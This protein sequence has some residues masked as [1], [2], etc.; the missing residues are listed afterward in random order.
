MTTKKSFEYPHIWFYDNKTDPRNSRLLKTNLTK[1]IEER[2]LINWIN[3]NVNET[4]FDSRSVIDGDIQGFSWF[5][6][7]IK[8]DYS[9]MEQT[10]FLP[11]FFANNLSTCRINIFFLE[12]P[13]HWIQLII[14]HQ[15]LTY[16]TNTNEIPI[17]IFRSNCLV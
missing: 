11:S 10:N 14:L 7:N 3:F 15:S 4:F 2:N 9:E 1:E 13:W 5:Y 8:W 17:F 6:I 12:N 16:S